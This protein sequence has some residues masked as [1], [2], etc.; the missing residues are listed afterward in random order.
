MTM[1]DEAI[2]L[3]GVVLDGVRSACGQTALDNLTDRYMGPLNAGCQ[4]VV[5]GRATLRSL[6]DVTVE[7]VARAQV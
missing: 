6:L 1:T 4:K 3:R 5:D 7:L 2:K